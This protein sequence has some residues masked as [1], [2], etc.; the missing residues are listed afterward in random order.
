MHDAAAD[1]V[2]HMEALMAKYHDLPMDLAD[3][4]LMAAAEWSGMRGVFT[5]DRDFRVH[6]FA[7]G[8]AVDV[9]P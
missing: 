3:A 8:A 9:I 4:S 2:A 5:L 6:R 1:E 7:A